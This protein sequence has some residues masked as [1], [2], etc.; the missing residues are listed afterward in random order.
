MSETDI[1]EVVLLVARKFV[2]LQSSMLDLLDDSLSGAV[3]EVGVL[4]LTHN[5]HQ[6]LYLIEQWDGTK[7]T[8]TTWTWTIGQNLV[9]GNE[10]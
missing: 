10:R 5:G 9:E 6:A 7:P 2:A 1:D 3:P 8:A 4:I